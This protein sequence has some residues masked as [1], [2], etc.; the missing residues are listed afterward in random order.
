V[1]VERT[2]GVAGPGRVFLMGSAINYVLFLFA[3]FFFFFGG[4]VR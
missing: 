1:V 3:F 4:E 2:V